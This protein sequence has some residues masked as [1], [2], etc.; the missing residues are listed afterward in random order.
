M[1]F[2]DSISA[3]LPVKDSLILTHVGIQF[4]GH[5]SSKTSDMMI[6]L[7]T[8]IVLISLNTLIVQTSAFFSEAAIDF[9]NEPVQMS[10]MQTLFMG[11][12]IA[13]TAVLSAFS[14]LPVY[15]DPLFI[16]STGRSFNNDHTLDEF[17]SIL[18]AVADDHQSH[19]THGA[20]GQQDIAQT[21][22]LGQV[23]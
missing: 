11:F 9:I 13:L 8:G 22:L 6:V 21:R 20:S 14:Y 2:V 7:S 1:I 19:E 16:S 17:F 12:F 23:S 15:A 5:T 10:P 3:K 4:Q 18:D